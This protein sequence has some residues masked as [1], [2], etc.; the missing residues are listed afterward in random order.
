MGLNKFRD[1]AKLHRRIVRVEAEVAGVG[2]VALRV[3]EGVAEAEGQLTLDW[4]DHATAEMDE[5]T[6]DELMKD[7]VSQ[8]QGEA[9][10]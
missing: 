1:P 4:L 7:S 6:Y 2:D 5:S 10:P 8:E 3:R 9:R